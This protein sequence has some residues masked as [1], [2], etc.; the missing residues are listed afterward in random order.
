[1]VYYGEGRYYLFAKWGRDCLPLN[2]KL[3]SLERSYIGPEILWPDGFNYLLPTSS[4][5]QTLRRF[6]AINGSENIE[7][8][9]EDE[10][11]SSE[12]YFNDGFTGTVYMVGDDPGLGPSYLKYVPE[13]Q[14]VEEFRKQLIRIP[15]RLTQQSLEKFEGNSENWKYSSF[16]GRFHE[17]LENEDAK[18]WCSFL[19]EI[20]CPN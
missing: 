15:R 20:G 11:Y 4:F 1:M 5:N 13:F 2:G 3:K 7:V 16:T 10:L 14:Y 12:K 6:E 9:E 8:V 17:I 19:Q 18:N